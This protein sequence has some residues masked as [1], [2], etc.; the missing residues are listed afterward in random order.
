VRNGPE[1]TQREWVGSLD[2]MP[3]WI[4]LEPGTDALTGMSVSLANRDRL[5]AWIE[6]HPAPT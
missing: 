3:A 2:E 4:T 1:G 6:A 5:L